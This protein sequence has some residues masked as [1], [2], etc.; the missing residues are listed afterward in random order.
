MRFIGNR[1]EVWTTYAQPKPRQNG[2]RQVVWRTG[3][4]V[5]LEKIDHVEFRLRPYRHFITFKNVPAGP[6]CGSSSDGRAPLAPV[7]ANARTGST[8][9]RPGS[10]WNRDRTAADRAKRSARGS[11]LDSRR[12]PTP[13]RLDWP[14]RSHYKVQPM[15]TDTPAAMKAR[16]AIGHGISL[17][18]F[19]VPVQ[20]HLSLSISSARDQ[21]PVPSFPPPLAR[22]WS[23]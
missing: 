6:N 3:G 10:R 16:A 17:T 18:K 5:A 23:P 21:Y 9:H 13:G 19:A 8:V 4:D 12:E 14:Q 20:S 11:E 2:R 15:E 1:P 22:V 7:A